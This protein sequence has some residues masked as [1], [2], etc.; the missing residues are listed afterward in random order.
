MIEPVNRTPLATAAGGW[1]NWTIGT[2]AKR[3]LIAPRPLTIFN[4]PLV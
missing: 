4:E 1:H 3:S 2:T